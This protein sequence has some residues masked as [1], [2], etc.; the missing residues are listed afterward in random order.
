MPKIIAIMLFLDII[1]TISFL[2]MPKTRMKITH[3][4]TIAPIKGSEKKERKLGNL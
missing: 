4:E 2:K 1:K 3:N